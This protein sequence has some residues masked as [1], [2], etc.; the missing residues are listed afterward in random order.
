MYD[1]NFQ[2]HLCTCRQLYST[3]KVSPLTFQ[4]IPTCV[5]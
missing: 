4:V 3:T 5:G 2:K 1:H